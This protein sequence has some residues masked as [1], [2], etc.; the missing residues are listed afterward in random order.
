MQD[1]YELVFF[2]SRFCFEI[3]D[4]HIPKDSIDVS[5]ELPP[6]EI[7]N[8]GTPVNGISAETPPTF[9]TK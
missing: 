4:W 2:F 8:S 9:K 1:S 6:D 5:K 7:N 3:I